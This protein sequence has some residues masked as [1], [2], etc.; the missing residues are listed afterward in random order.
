MDS[1]SNPDGSVKLQWQNW[2]LRWIANPELRISAYRF[3]SCLQRYVPC[4]LNWYRTG[5]ENR[6]PGNGHGGSNPPHGVFSEVVQWLEHRSDMAG[7]VSS[8]LT[9]RT[10]GKRSEFRV[11]FFLFHRKIRIDK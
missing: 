6:Q 2:Q 8:N 7:V 5:L 1:G 11:F 9:L 3:K 4:C 10:H